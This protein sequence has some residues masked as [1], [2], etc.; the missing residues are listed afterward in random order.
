L[1]K[2]GRGGRRKR[3]ERKGRGGEE[4]T[5]MGPVQLALDSS[6]FWPQN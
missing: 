1:R 2:G 3:R 4:G 6:L 5:M